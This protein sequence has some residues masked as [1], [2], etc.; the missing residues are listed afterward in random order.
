MRP[1]PLPLHPRST[2]RTIW[3]VCVVLFA[4]SVVEGAGKAP[5]TGT[6]TPGLWVTAE[7]GTPTYLV[8]VT[9]G[10]VT[11]LDAADGRVA[12][13][14][15][16]TD[17]T[18]RAHVAVA[19]SVAVVSAGGFHLRG[20]DVATGG[21]LWT[22]GINDVEWDSLVGRSYE[23]TTDGD[24]IYLITR[25]TNGVAALEPTTGAIIWRHEDHVPGADRRFIKTLPR[26][27]H[28]RIRD[29]RRSD[30]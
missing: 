23:L 3:G 1:N 2:F 20:I 7:R 27:P 21:L 22:R 13:R 5:T 24:K 6:V 17:V 16:L 18:P 10:A 19:H 9:A 28:N 15:P 11:R 8:V 25:K 4:L 12:W 29:P 14:Q 26:A 30:W